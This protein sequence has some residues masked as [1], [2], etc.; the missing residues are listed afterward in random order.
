MHTRV[1]VGYI[2]ISLGQIPR[3][4][5]AVS[6]GKYMFNFLKKLPHCLTQRLCHFTFDKKH[7]G[8]NF[9]TY[10][11][12]LGIVTLFDHNYPS[13]CKVV[14][15]VL[16]YLFPVT[17]GVEHLFLCLLAVGIISLIKCLFKCFVNIC[18]VC[19]PTVVIFKIYILDIILTSKGTVF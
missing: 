14:S 3:R 8:S 17:N 19:L 5:I 7:E 10:L 9:F 1:C 6:Y 16:I 18:V 2:S 12:T 11:P 4:G 15:L 13:G